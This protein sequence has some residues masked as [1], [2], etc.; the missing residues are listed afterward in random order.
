MYACCMLRDT[1]SCK[2]RRGRQGERSPQLSL[3]NYPSL[4]NLPQRPWVI[5]APAWPAWISSG[6]LKRLGAASGCCVRRKGFPFPSTGRSSPAVCQLLN[7]SLHWA[8]SLLCRPLNSPRRLSYTTRPSPPSSSA[9]ATLPPC[10]P[11]LILPLTSHRQT[12]CCRALHVDVSC[13]VQ[14]RIYSI[15]MYCLHINRVPAQYRLITII[16]TV[17]YLARVGVRLRARGAGVRW[18]KEDGN[19]DGVLRRS[20]RCSF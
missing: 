7:E 17:R 2:L 14:Q 12:R 18:V 6:P 9:P 3:D 15:S 8:P 10:H 5:L 4:A 20:G 13:I 16:E 1:T 19:D 11:A